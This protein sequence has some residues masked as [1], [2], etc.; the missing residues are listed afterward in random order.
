MNAFKFIFFSLLVF[1][2]SFKSDFV[3]QSKKITD[4]YYTLADFPS[5]KKFDI[6]T[7]INTTDPT[8][9]NQAK[10]DNFKFLDIVDDR[11][12]GLPMAE[13]QKIAIF[14]LGKF[15]QQMAFAT[16]FKVK[17]FND[18]DWAEKTIDDLKHSFSQGA[19]AVKIWK[20]IGLDLRDKN[21]K[22]VMID[23]PRIDPVL[24]YLEEN[25]IPVIGHNGEPKDCWLP[26][27]KMLF[28]RDYYSAHPEYHMYLHPEYPSYQA[29]MDARDNVLKRHPKLRF[30]GA[31]LGSLEWSLDE[32]AKRL[33]SYPNMSV[34]LSRMTN[35][36]L[37][38]LQNHEKACN[39]FIKY[40]DRLVYGTDRAVNATQN[41]EALAKE[42]HSEWLN[43]WKFYVTDDIITL[44]GFGTLKGLKLPK[45]VIDKIYFKNAEK[46]L[47]GINTK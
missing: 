35:L 17:N 47:S 2:L 13:Q 21:G 38:A 28:S 33:D 45:Q 22:F 26:L 42:T 44:N 25:N 18:D 12:F 34:D 39:F 14:D 16:T 41:K 6:H 7:H 20:N 36:Q 3:H 43:D 29:Q 31:H 8:F 37:H 10:K 11:P 1:P 4:T 23:D 32:L 19:H 46:W 24:N 27:D 5:V 15:P 9:I 40:Q 30:V